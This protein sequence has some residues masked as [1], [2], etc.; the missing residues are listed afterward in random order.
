MKVLMVGTGEYTT[1]YVHDQA[2]DSDK[3]AGVVA[4]TM[5]DLRRRGMVEQV[6]MA[7]TNGR[8]MPG[9]RDHLRRVIG[10]TY[11]DLDVTAQCFPADDVDRDPTAYQRAIKALDPGD[12]VTVFTPDD[13]HFAI[14]MDAIRHG[15]HVLIAKPIVMTVDQHQQLIR[16]ADDA[17]VLVAM[18]VHKRWDPI[19]ADARDRIRNLG[20]F[21]FFHAYMSQPK[22]QLDTFRSWAGKSS[23]I[24]Y[25]LNAHH[26]DFL[27]W[28]I[29]SMATPVSVPGSAATGFAKGHGIDTEDTITLTVDWAMKDGTATGTAVF[30]SSW[31]APKSDV[32][33]QQRFF[34]MGHQ[35]E[36]TV[37]QA[38]RGYGV[39][40]DGRGFQSV[41]PLFMKYTPDAEGRFAGQTGYGYRSIEAFVQ[42]AIKIR[43]GHATPDDFHGRLATA[44]DTINVTAIL[45][46]GR[47]SL[48]TG[49]TI[50]L[51]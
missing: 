26:I 25:Y 15:C 7:G 33:S 21:G 28:S 48:D 24:S 30:T 40:T 10:D 11:A 29:G 32:H 45:Q 35:G 5:F 14:A 13:T 38:H 31:I 49:T 20:S 3:S 46:A 43:R 17:G 27:N 19:Y 8:K 42:A 22:S 12:V 37:D 2:S 18:E 39:A 50:S 44:K 47:R 6:S 4:L 34:Y 9:I 23:D 1:G 51:D 16:A 36:V 41:N